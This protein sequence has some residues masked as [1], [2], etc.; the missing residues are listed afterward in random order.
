MTYD[1]YQVL[2]RCNAALTAKEIA[3]Q[4]NRD[5]RNLWDSINVLVDKGLIVRSKKIKAPG[6]GRGSL[7]TLNQELIEKRIRELQTALIEQPNAFAIKGRWRKDVLRL[8]RE[9]DA[10]YTP[11][12]VTRIL[13]LKR[14]APVVSTLN[15]F[16]KKGYTY[17]LSITKVVVV[18]NGLN[19][20]MQIYCYEAEDNHGR[21]IL[22]AYLDG[23]PKDPTK[24]IDM[25]SYN[26]F[27]EQQNGI[28]KKISRKPQYKIQGEHNGQIHL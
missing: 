1:I 7:L 19:R 22:V 26:T 3:P 16:F 5:E 4:V 18:G 24:E 8:M 28:M 10:G 11:Q 17:Y 14:V 2:R 21:P 27:I 25:T 13:D 20:G 9:S 6:G 12:E 15:L 23:M